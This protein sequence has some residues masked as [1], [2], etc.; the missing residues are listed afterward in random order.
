MKV[1]SQKKFS[2]NS[3]SVETS[4]H[5]TPTVIIEIKTL[6]LF[7][8]TKGQQACA[9]GKEGQGQCCLGTLVA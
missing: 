5:A 2:I 8:A 6:V 1:I 7:Q 4:D 9:E 3:V